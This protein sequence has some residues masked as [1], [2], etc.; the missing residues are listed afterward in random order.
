M[1]Q[2]AIMDL[3]IKDD[4]WLLGGQRHYR[5]RLLDHMTACVQSYSML[6]LRLIRS[7]V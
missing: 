6:C 7:I 3:A 5:D 1:M 4:G 2:E